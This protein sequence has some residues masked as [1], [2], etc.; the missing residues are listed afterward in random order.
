MALRAALV[1]VVL[2]GL[3]SCR[4]QEQTTLAP[5]LERPASDEVIYFV[6]ADRF[7][8]ADPSNDRG[9]LSG[10]RLEHGFDPT[11]KGFF[12]G[13]DLKGLTQ[14]LDYIR[15]LGAT[16]IWL[17]PIYKNRP[18]QGRPGAESAGY[19]GYWITDFTDVDPH[20]GDRD[21]FKDFVDAA[22]AQNMKVY[23]DIV[24]NHTADVIY[25][26]ECHGLAADP[27]VSE[28]GACPYRDTLQKPYVF[29][30]QGELR[31]EGFL[32]DRGQALN[33][34]N[35]ANLTDMTYAYTP[36]VPEGQEAVKVPA[37]LNDVRFYHNRGDSFWEGESATHGDFQGLDD[38]FTEH[39]QVLSGFIDIYKQWIT[40]FRIDGFRI[41]TAKHVNPEFWPPFNTAMI[42][43]ARSLGIPNFHI[44]GEV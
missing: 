38:V 41:D 12:H 27:D 29:K 21:D 40:D 32:G 26:E 17:T 42:E 39:P 5:Y 36:V 14:R 43:H 24:V 7:E 11:H 33:A 4:A 30:K 22:H 19:H 1:L 25:Y 37:W 16:A 20:L 23:L 2:A 44:F 18:V 10:G 34:E 28:P 6:M 31:N 9:G 13:G 3:I 35:F 15:G 8:N